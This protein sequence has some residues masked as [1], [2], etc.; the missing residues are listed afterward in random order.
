M[1]ETLLRT[2]G[3][4][5]GVATGDAIGK[6]TESLNFEEIKQWFPEGVTGLHGES[7]SVMPRYEGRHYLWRFGETTDDTE[8]T[9]S[10]ARVIANDGKITHTSVGQELMLCKKSNRP[11]L[12]LGKFQQI[13]DPKR[14]AF[15]GDG[16]GAA[17]RSAPIGVLYSTQRL[18]D[19]VSSVFEASIPTHGG[20]IAIC[21][22]SAIAAAVSAAIDEKQPYEILQHS[23]LAAKT[24]EKY[25]PA[26]SDESVADLILRVYEDLLSQES[27]S[28]EFIKDKYMPWKTP[29]IIALAINF[30]ILTQSAEKTT[31]LAANLGGDTDSVASMGSAI[32]GAMS[33]QTVNEEWYQ[34]VK[35]V[36]GNELLELAPRIA[37]LRR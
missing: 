12:L 26:S 31:L 25:R 18:N 4:F 37:S 5:K 1:E 27:L 16:C 19:L 34:A 23:I 22:A 17:M 9:T 13:G 30:A 36:N 24:A 35:E 7:G 8:Q 28:L 3:C 29:N 14:V 33:P 2:I 10:I 11:T 21:G 6:Q 15:E 20:R 32:A